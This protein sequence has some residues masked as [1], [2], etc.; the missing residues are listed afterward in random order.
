MASTAVLTES[1]LA[2]STG[3]KRRGDLEKYLQEQGIKFFTGKG[4]KLWTTTGLVEAAK[5]TA[6]NGE[7]EFL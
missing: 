4:G 2:E 7:I 6:Q 3:Y 5:L 1:Q